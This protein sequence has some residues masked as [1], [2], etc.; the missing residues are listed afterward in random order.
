[1]IQAESWSC[2]PWYGI[3]R[4][5][6]RPVPKSP[7]ITAHGP[8][9]HHDRPW[10]RQESRILRVLAGLDVA[11]GNVQ[12]PCRLKA[13]ALQHD[14]SHERHTSQVRVVRQ[15]FRPHH[16]INLP[17]SVLQHPKMAEHTSHFPVYASAMRYSL[18]SHQKKL[19]RSQWV[20]QS[21]QHLLY[22]LQEFQLISMS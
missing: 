21:G 1:M 8:E 5:E 9:V 6:T 3:H 15:A 13:E 14:A 12:S 2:F 18:G 4:A 19:L 11:L 17:L 10:S 16:R 7:R 20:D 22:E